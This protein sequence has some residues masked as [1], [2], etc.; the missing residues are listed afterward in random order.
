MHEIQDGIEFR[1]YHWED[2][3]GGDKFDLKNQEWSED[4]LKLPKKHWQVE[5]GQITQT[6]L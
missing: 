5:K 6:F 4:W 1:H 3:K 2:L